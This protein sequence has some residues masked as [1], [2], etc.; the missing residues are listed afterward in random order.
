MGYCTK[1][2]KQNSD[3]AKFC[4]GCGTRLG[5]V[6]ESTATYTSDKK[7]RKKRNLHWPGILLL[8]I[9]TLAGAG[10]F[11]FF[12]KKQDG[13]DKNTIAASE[14]VPSDRNQT[15]PTVMAD[16]SPT[17]NDG[18]TNNNPPNSGI[19]SIIR[20]YFKMSEARNFNNLYDTYLGS[21]ERY[22][23]KGYPT[24]AELQQLF[25]HYY[26]TTTNSLHDIK[27]IRVT[28]YP[29]YDEAIVTLNYSYL[30]IKTQEYK[31]LF[32]LKVQ[33]LFDKHGQITS[34]TSMK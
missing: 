13:R 29:D 14:Q 34:I 27:D 4:T 2:G 18:V 10:Y 23:E 16:A 19:P 32:G 24:R 6:T 12:N 15:E 5:I 22:Y 20:S 30:F 25:E 31:T 21:I 33:F 28:E 7:Q 17:E 26:S 8:G 9:L 3:T 11:I 1:C